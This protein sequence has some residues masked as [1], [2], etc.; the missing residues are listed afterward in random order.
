MVPRESY[1][2]FRSKLVEIS[3]RSAAVQHRTVFDGNGFRGEG[4][5]ERG[6]SIEKD[7]FRDLVEDSIGYRA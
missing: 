3:S 2:R 6:R 5:E 4:V 1:L 7:E